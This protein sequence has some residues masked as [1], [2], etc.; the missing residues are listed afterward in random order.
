MDKT[1]VHFI[2]EHNSHYEALARKID[3]DLANLYVWSYGHIRLVDQVP[4]SFKH[5]PVSWHTASIHTDGRSI[6]GDNLV[7]Y[8][9]LDE[10]E[11]AL[12]H[13]MVSEIKPEQGA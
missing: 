9:T 7:G 6:C 11:R 5:E 8:V 3:G 4:H 2:D 1:T 12:F 10:I 13:S